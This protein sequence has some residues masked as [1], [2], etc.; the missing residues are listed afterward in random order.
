MLRSQSTAFDASCSDSSVL[1]IRTIRVIVQTQPN[2]P[3]IRD[4]RASVTRFGSSFHRP[5]RPSTASTWSQGQGLHLMLQLRGELY[6]VAQSESVFFRSRFSAVISATTF[7]MRWFSVANL[8]I[9]RSSPFCFLR[10]KTASAEADSPHRQS[11]FPGSATLLHALDAFAP[12][13]FH[14][15]QF[16]FEGIE[17]VV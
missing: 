17:F 2:G 11:D 12:G 5:S 15:R 7:F 10:P 6:V 16:R 9:R 4:R 13:G 14:Q 8:A 1:A 3:R